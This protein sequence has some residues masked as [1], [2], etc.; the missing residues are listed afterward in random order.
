MWLETD[1]FGS[2]HTAPMSYAV[3]DEDNEWLVEFRNDNVIRIIVGGGGG[4]VDFMT[5]P[6]TETEAEIRKV[7]NDKAC[8]LLYVD[9]VY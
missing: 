9:M 8:M 4:R 5:P 3:Q 7:R 2:G 1:D 6:R